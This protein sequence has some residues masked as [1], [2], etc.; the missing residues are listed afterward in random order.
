[1]RKITR[2]L[3]FSLIILPFFSIGQKSERIQYK[4]DELFEF[5]E[6]GK[7][8]RKLTGNVVF[9]QEGTTM[10]CDSSLYYV[11]DN[12]MEAFGHVKIVDD[13]TIITS[14]KLVYDGKKKTAKLREQV[15]YTHGEQQLFTDFLDYNTDTEVANY[16]NGG[17]L[18][19][20]TNTLS[21]EIGYLYN[22]EDYAQ[23]RTNVSLKA[24]DYTL[25][26]DTLNYDTNTKVAVT[27]GR[28]V[29]TNE[30]G[31]VLHAKGGEFR[32]E[33]DQ[34]DFVNGNIETEDYYLE[35]DE[36]FFDD[37]NQYYK[38]VGNVQIIG[39]NDDVILY[40]DEGFTDKNREISKVYGHAYMKRMLE[41]DT[42]YISADTL[43]SI[44]SE[45][46]SAKRV[47]A[48]N[49]VKLWRYNL[50]GVADSASY[51][52]S[53]STILLYNDPLIW[54]L[55]NQIEGDSIAIEISEDQIK[56]MTVLQNSFLIG[57][58]TI[59]NYNQVKGRTM[60]A[61]FVEGI[62][63]R[64][65]V[66]GN[67]EAL[68]YVLD[69]SDS[70]EITTMGMNRILCSDLTMRFINEEL[71]NIS[72]YKKPEA[73]FIPPHELT[74]DMQRLK[75]FLWR[76]DDRPT[77]EEVVFL[78]EEV[79]LE[80][81]SEESEEQKPIPPVKIDIEGIPDKERKLLKKPKGGLE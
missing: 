38:A 23:F 4:A 74:D 68:Y 37:L 32:T 46:D 40:G 72:F 55:D 57:I 26:S 13:S 76:G 30:D 19:D 65:D 36:L 47:L 56:T 9:A 71:D 27:L 80:E 67:G 66:N 77:F 31:S 20:S 25:E 51:F 11:R 3:I 15:V 53:D 78:S 34:S 12:V 16:F 42:F 59:S 44:D 63:S 52:L 35:G 6:K 22:L 33:D 79:E 50:Q 49:N 10:Y 28:T 21:S 8:I 62:I 24:P 75:G 69:E 45:Y 81:A 18:K 17:T 29:I 41:R 58:D 14:N 64:I 2:V 54:N 60:K 5:R 70:T 48:Y 61:T 43:V 39:K 7:K 1:M 73:K